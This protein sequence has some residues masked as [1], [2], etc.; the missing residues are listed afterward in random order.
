MK[1]TSKIEFK[2]I[3]GDIRFWII[4][5]FVLRLYGITNPPLEPASTWRQC[6]VLMIARNF[7]EIDSNIFYPRVDLAG[8]QSGIVGVEFPFYNYLIY[9]VSL[10][11]GYND[12]Y[13]RIINLIFTSVGTYFYYKSITRFFGEKAGLYSSILLLVTGWFSYSR[14][15]LPDTFAASIC[16][17]ALHF[18]FNYFETKRKSHLVAFTFIALLGCLSKISSASLLTVLLIP[19]INSRFAL[20]QKIGLTISAG[21]ILSVVCLW[22]FQWVP[23]LYSIGFNGHFFMGMPFKDGAEQ[24]FTHLP[25][26]LEK[27]Y[28]SPMKYSGFSIFVLSIILVVKSRRIGPLF[29][30]LIP[31]AGFLVF[32]FK[33]GWGFYVNG[34]YFVMFLP[35]MALITGYGI[36]LMKRTWI[37]ITLL[38][39][40]GVEN[41]ANQ[42]HVFQ[43]REPILAYSKLEIILDQAG[44]NQ[45]DLIAINSPEGHNPTPMYMAHRKGW[46]VPNDYLLNQESRLSIKQRGCKYVLI[47]KKNF[48]DDVT[49][50]L[51][52]IYNSLDFKIY[53][54]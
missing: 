50:P 31:F 44:V 53:K 18:A 39:I 8:E 37:Q 34:Y 9:L 46:N 13:G 51:P 33:S 2:L 29:A 16:I 32:A 25:L 23:H 49:L 30:F 21:I 24:I 1:T 54:L 28:D 14:V 42:I 26:A 20:T 45:K 4:L 7:F 10:L 36:S 48:S 27:I 19:M 40:I 43:I 15:T 41:I 12:W 47:L 38:L 52:E 35:S 11:F 22:Y 17:I 5:F 3:L 6:D